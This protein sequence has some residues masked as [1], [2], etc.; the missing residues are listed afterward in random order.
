MQTLCKRP[1]DLSVIVPV[2]NLENY[3]APLLYSLKTQEVGNY[4]VE[5]LFV[6]NNCTDKSEEK[7]KESGL[8]CKILYCDIQGCGEARNVGMDEATGKFIWFMDGDDWLLTPFAIRTVLDKVIPND[9]D[10]CRVQYES[11]KFTYLYYSMVWQYIFKR[12]FIADCRFINIEPC[13]DDRYM[14]LVLGK[15]GLNSETYLRLPHTDYPL[16]YYNYLREGS[17]MYRWHILGERNLLG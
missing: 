4:T 3:I 8:E 16:Y 2:Y 17:N 9:Y 6:L 11:E 1:P 10:I 7:I 13:E 14:D 5:Y 12:E 15:M